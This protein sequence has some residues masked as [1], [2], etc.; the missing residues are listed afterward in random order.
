MSAK[1]WHRVALVFC[2]LL[3]AV[4]VIS[5]FAPTDA[6]GT[7]CPQMPIV[8]AFSGSGKCHSS[9]G[10]VL[11]GALA[12][13]AVGAA[14]LLFLRWR[15]RHAVSPAPASEPSA[16]RI[17]PSQ[18]AD[19][20]P[21]PL[22]GQPTTAPTGPQVNVIGGRLGFPK[23]SAEAGRLRVNSRPMRRPLD[24]EPASVQIATFTPVATGD[25]NTLPS[26]WG[27]RRGSRQLPT[28][29]TLLFRSP[30]HVGPFWG[31]R[32]GIQGLTRGE[33]RHGRDLDIFD[34]AVED[35]VAA[36]ALLLGLGIEVEK[37]PE[38]ILRAR[39]GTADAVTLAARDHLRRSTAGWK[40][41]YAAVTATMIGVTVALR[42]AT[43]NGDGPTWQQGALWLVGAALG[44][45]VGL[46]VGSRWTPRAATQNRAAAVVVVA[47]WLGGIGA[48]IACAATNHFGL[49]ALGLST[50]AGLGLQPAAPVRSTP[51]TSMFPDGPAVSI[52][53]AGDPRGIRALRSL[54]RSLAVLVALLVGLIALLTVVSARDRISIAGPAA[55][56]PSMAAL[57]SIGQDVVAADP[58]ARPAPVD[59]SL[60]G[61]PDRS[62]IR[63]VRAEAWAD[64][65]HDVS[66]IVESFENRGDA[67]SYHQAHTRADIDNFRT[68]TRQH[69][70]VLGATAFTCPCGQADVMFLRGDTRV[71]VQISP[72]IADPA[73]TAW[74][75]A[76]QI[77]QRLQKS[78]PPSQ[79]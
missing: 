66:V 22:W 70:P 74:R 39:F 71:F 17:S 52:D 12:F 15:H 60:G 56:D 64:A 47:G 76:R 61:V 72:P 59:V 35:G 73:P 38:P 41:G 63:P 45:G 13:F 55:P 26:R 4:G 67:V 5:C 29:L 43:A 57:S 18:P 36:H 28:T 69:P 78:T 44:G 46:L 53:Q 62:G 23:L 11:I 27:I 37:D 42:I 14:G 75:L 50:G 48:T 6:K 3:I 68:V 25:L 10:D 33:I 16:A 77:D 34:L 79:P 31:G 40:A 19:Q 51:S 58:S 21:G 32:S 9:S 2:W 54:H 30:Q 8:S 65:Q 24:I 20:P 7:S 1:L 49:T